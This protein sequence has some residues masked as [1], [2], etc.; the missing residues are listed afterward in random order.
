MNPFGRRKHMTLCRRR[1]VSQNRHEHFPLTPVDPGCRPSYV[2]D[3]STPSDT[4]S[5]EPPFGVSFNLQRLP[6]R[7]IRRLV[8]VTS[9]PLSNR[10]L[11]GHTLSRHTSSLIRYP[12]PRPLLSC[13]L[14]RRR[15]H[16]D[17]ASW[18]VPRTLPPWTSLLRG[19]VSSRGL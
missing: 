9:S 5:S 14:R 2:H 4:L 18:S 1:P 7:L 13:D 10:G 3:D 11:F 8:Y 12:T 19:S 15:V 6:L 16:P 17:T